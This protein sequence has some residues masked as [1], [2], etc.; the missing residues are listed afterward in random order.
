ML[1]RHKSFN[2]G[3]WLQEERNY[4][5][6]YNFNETE[7]ICNVAIMSLESILDKYYFDDE[8]TKWY[9]EDMISGYVGVLKSG[10][11]NIHKVIFVILIKAL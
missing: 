10:K 3:K 5:D 6:R 7:S 2:T 1:Q 11:N 4:K 9:I 8:E